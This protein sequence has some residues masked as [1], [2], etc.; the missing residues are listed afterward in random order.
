MAKGGA[1]TRPPAVSPCMAESGQF[2]TLA[3]VRARTLERLLR[4]VNG[5][6]NIK[7]NEPTAV[8][9]SFTALAA[10]TLSRDECSLSL[11]R[12]HL[13][14]GRSCRPRLFCRK[15]ELAGL[16]ALLLDWKSGISR[17]GVNSRDAEPEPDGPVHRRLLVDVS[18]RWVKKSGSGRPNPRHHHLQPEPCVSSRSETCTSLSEPATAMPG[19]HGRK[20]Y[21]TSKVSFWHAFRMPPLAIQALWPT[22]SGSGSTSQE[23]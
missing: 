9:G 17:N 11:M 23:L 3:G 10:V 13:V 21:L 5:P 4:L 12:F 14:T 22:R 20:G 8:D 19:G 6:S 18:S 16:R 2:P 15:P 7:Q 1:G